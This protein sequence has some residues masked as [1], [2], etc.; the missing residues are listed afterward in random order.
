V[1]NAQPGLPILIGLAGKVLDENEQGRQGATVSLFKSG[2]SSNPV[3]VV[4]TDSAGNFNLA[5][6]EGIY[7][8]EVSFTGFVNWIKDS[9]ILDGSQPSVSIPGILLK[10]SLESTLAEA[11]VVHPRPMFEQKD[12]TITLNVESTPMS[13]SGSGAELIKNMPMVATDPEG[14]IVV[15]GKQPII[16]IDEKPVDMNGQQLADLLESLPGSSIEKIELMQNP[17][18][19]Y[20]NS[21]GGVIN[22]VTKKG[23]VGWT[24]KASVMAGTIG[25]TNANINL[26]YRNKK[27]TFSGVAG[28]NIARVTGNSYSL[29]ENQYQDSTNQFETI[30][31]YTNRSTRPNFRVQAGYE[32]NPRN[33]WSLTVQ[34]NG[35]WY[36]NS[37]LSTYKN[38]NRFDEVWK[39][40]ERHNRSEGN[41]VSVQAQLGYT[42][43]GKNRAEKLQV[44]ASYTPA[45]GESDRL[46]FQEFLT[47]EF[48]KTGVD[49]TQGQ[50]SHNPGG[51]GLLKADYQKPLKNKA[52][53]FTSGAALSILHQHNVL[54]TLYWDKV[55]GEAIISPLLSTDNKFRQQVWSARAGM[56]IRFKK[57]WTAIGNLQVEG[58]HFDFRFAGNLPSTENDYLSFLP[59]LTIR[60]DINKL[61]K[62]SFVYRKSIRRPGMYELNP[63][64]DYGDPYNLR[65][66]NPYL[67]PS[68]AKN[69]DLNLNWN[70]GKSYING[71]LGF[72]KVDDIINRIRTLMEDGK[73]YATFQ[74]IATR[75]E[76]E[77]GIWSGYSFSK[78]WRL[79]FSGS[80]VYNVYGEKEKELLKYQDGSSVTFNL[81]GNFTASPLL[82]FDASVRYNAFAD[83]QGRS[84]S[85][86][87]S[88][89]GAQYKML[90]RRLILAAAAIDPFTRQQ[91]TSVSQ[92]PNF[93]IYSYRTAITRNFRLSASWVLQASKKR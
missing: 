62:A 6:P 32:M 67:S 45:N 16:L 8:V 46:F 65:F 34:G 63:A 31:G 24:G 83:P 7:R 81:N 59:S 91:I 25:Q 9:I 11:V 26:N 47:P 55:T 10:P 53:T 48:E 68:S 76:Y 61:L 56:N 49:S 43:F 44:V 41:N 2:V 19:Q 71:S 92:G 82:A 23:S 20:A 1:V 22:I 74:N 30:S 60:K 13:G 54:Q 38:I 64:V 27:I 52:F 84:R 72:N 12:G 35:N 78:K 5:V 93:Y 86:I 89:M 77:V 66:G 4:S 40:S 42:L 28:I 57:T 21:E 29:R 50:I 37:S 73:T 51:N 75:K 88:Q 14:R 15:K 69:Y 3:R 87:S 39:L 36:E 79:N 80:Y 70:N 90:N 17:P 58:T 33:L 18:P 85:N